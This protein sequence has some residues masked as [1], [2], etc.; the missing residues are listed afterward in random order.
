M[1]YVYTVLFVVALTL[2]KIKMSL[3]ALIAAWASIRKAN[4]R[5]AE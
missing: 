4:I 3:S 1:F 2:K 5:D